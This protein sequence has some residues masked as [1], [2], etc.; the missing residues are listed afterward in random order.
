MTIFQ[1][2]VI[3]RH[4]DNLDKK[5]VEK[6]YQKFRENY[7]P[8]KIEEIKKLKEEEYQD[9]FLRDIFVDVF[10]YILKPDSNYNLA[11][12]FK[13]QGD[14]KKADGA[15]LKNEK[16]VAIIELKST[17]TKDLKS[18]TEQAFNYKN[19]QPECKY[20]I[21]SN[22]QKLRFYI[23]YAHEYEE[24]DLFNL[25][26]EDFEL[27]YLLLSANSIFSNLPIKLKEETK[28]HEQQVSDKLYKD[29]SVFKNK[30]FANLIKNNPD[31]NKL[32]LFNKS[33]KLL[34]RFLFILFAED[35]GLLPPNSISRIIDTFHKLTE[36][37]A[38][39]PIYDIYKQYFGYMNIG[40]KGKTNA[41]NIPAYNGGLFYTDELLDNLKIDDSILI[42]DLLKLSEYDFNTEVDV[43]I[44]GHIF[45]HSLSDIE[46]ITAEIEGTTTDKT[47]SKRKKD[48]VFY[49]PKYITQYIVENTIGTLCTEKRKELEIEEIE[50]DGSY[51][52]KDGK[53][54]TKGKKLY[55]KLNNYKDWLLSLKIVD[56]ACGSGAFLNQALNFLIA[57][58]KNI[59]DIIAELTNTALR[60]FDTD[61]AILEN[62]LYGVD[63]NEESVE[64][65]KLSLWLR[66]AQKGR[67]LSSLNDNIK[68]G[69][70]LIDDP[71]IA[72][73][74]AFNWNMEFPQVYKK[75]EKKAWHITTATHNSRYSER[76]F[77]NHVKLGEAVWISK[78]DEI[79][80]TKTIAN[81]IKE[82]N[83][84][85]IEYNICGDH[86]H[87][88]L[89]CE[90]E[91]LPKIVGKIKAISGRK[92]NIEN[93]ITVVATN[94]D[95][96]RGHVPF[97]ESSTL[98]ESPSPS[99]EDTSSKKTE[100][101]KYNSL[102]TQKFGKR[103]I[104]GDTD[105]NNVINYIH[106]NRQKHE[107]PI[108]TELEKI[109][110]EMT[111]SI[112]QAFRTEYNGGFDVVIGNPPYVRIQQLDY[113]TIDNLKT[114]Y[115]TALKRIDISLCFVELSSRLIKPNYGLTSFIT[116]NQFL[117]TEYGQAMRAFLLSEYNIVECVDFGDLPIFADAL[118]YVS[119]FTFKKSIINS[120]KYYHVDSIL[121][122]MSS[123]YGILQIIETNQLT[124]A[125]WNLRYYAVSN[126]LG[127]KFSNCK[128]ISEI[129]NS[130]YGIISGADSIFIFTKDQYQNSEIEKDLFIPL[131]RAQNCTKYY[132]LD[133][134]KFVIYPYK[135]EDEKTILLRENELQQKFP[136]GYQYLLSHKTELERRKDSRDTFKGRPDWYCLTR[137]GQFNVFNKLKIVT[138]GE[139]K[140]HK[141]CLDFTNAGFS[142]ARV[143]AITID[144][145]L[146]DVKYVLCILNSKLIKLYLQSF[147]SL[148]NGGFYSY[149]S[150]ILNK[151]P[152]KH[153]S[154]NEQQVFIL[155]AD[156]IYN[157][158]KDYKQKRNKFLNRINDNF[159][160]GKISKKLEVFYNYDFKTFIAELK[161][162]KIKLALVQ[163]DE[164][165]EYF[166]IYKNEINQLQDEINT[167]D[168]EIDQM[169]YKLYGLT[170]EEIKI[171]EESV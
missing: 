126:I 157:L 89:V 46:E 16:A 170:E 151:T 61:K 77:D 130:W 165:E 35:S 101:K 80:V 48:G 6:V 125:N 94:E 78:K 123:N 134:E 19:N 140:Q 114:H 39:K 146:F 96:T 59:D 103:K 149:S 110:H 117:T 9:G 141:F 160:I 156:K 136:K 74:K 69:N 7:S 11:R 84:N 43:N 50:F 33:Q 113:N 135:L 41:D 111:C 51:R 56:P 10:G 65:A 23:D 67:K 17:K 115:K 168:N 83:L 119:I 70:S 161:K 158:S 14:G 138:P 93:V 2:S 129:G 162:Q 147:S 109:I 52:A 107:L 73:E 15:I 87:I 91:E 145:E 97:S 106:T 45:E 3:K 27:L 159:E 40:R 22:F 34:D 26:K 12:E 169:V 133:S 144:N 90:K 4:L 164:W 131:L 5:Q 95:K 128:E 68:C 79:V 122:A 171:V 104:V 167:T 38:Y 112:E 72:G 102:W 18:I 166:N 58:H 21:T 62:N 54:L 37:D 31:N 71:E 148:K 108:N 137:F 116:S 105:L 49:T 24:F 81:I 32:T 53:L 142:G 86:M 153:I 139:V 88:L 42:N 127:K 150:N 155:L 154:Q 57:E 60:L 85:V 163:Q 92:Y 30:L 132:C 44:L 63:I 120:F 100:K 143:F 64:I 29:Y 152:I 1:K 75:K 121:N 55:Q 8:A 25:Q 20:V 36:L 13:N 47:K 99:G 82:D 76:M 124:D 66:T 118:T 98:S 28:F